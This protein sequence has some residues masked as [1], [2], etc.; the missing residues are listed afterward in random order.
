MALALA[1]FDD[2]EALAPD[3][4][5]FTASKLGWVTTGDLPAYAEWVPD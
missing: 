5:F 3:V 1:L 2:P 4:H